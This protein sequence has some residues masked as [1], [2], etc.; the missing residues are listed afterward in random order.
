MLRS[1]IFLQGHVGPF[2]RI[3]GRRLIS[4]GHRVVRIN[5]NGGDVFDWPGPETVV[6][7]NKAKEWPNYLLEL[8]QNN[9]ATDL[10][11][12]GDCRPQLRAATKLART[13]GVRC[14][15]FEMGYIRP[16]F[17][18][19]ED[20]G[21]NG[22]SLLPSQPE[23]YTDLAR[24]LPADAPVKPAR[25][26]MDSLIR[27]SVAYNLAKFAAQPF[28][29]RFRNHRPYGERTAVRCWTLKILQRRRQ[30][31]HDRH[32]Q[33]EFLS[34]GKKFFLFCLQLGSDYQIRFHSPFGDMKTAIAFVLTSFSRNLPA[35]GDLLVK[36]HPEELFPLELERFTRQ[37]A[38]GLGIEDRIHFTTGG[39]LD[40]YIVASQGMVTV[41]STAA[42]ASLDHNRPTIAMGKAVYR[43][44]G[45]IHGDLD[46]FWNDPVPPDDNLYRAFRKVLIHKTLINGN[47]FT[48]EGI[49]LAVPK[50]VKRL[51]GNGESISSP[52]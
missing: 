17:I 46:S 6:L 42:M 18:T 3:L 47:F 11:T 32:F 45:L 21:V 49:D 13:A 15:V 1:F 36:C 7:R 48:E 29:C 50:A 12:Y 25:Y 10:V 8:I 33:K 14:H 41:N 23:W 22:N 40:D 44:P 5:F 35:E 26:S 9:E 19:L 24:R 43:I 20:Y 31:L 4:E 2:F 27:H 51:T 52:I 28:F 30:L 34:S 38:Q 39:N 16:D 37:L